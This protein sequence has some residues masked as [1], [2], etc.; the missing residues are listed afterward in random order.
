MSEMSGTIL[1][2]YCSEQSRAVDGKQPLYEQLVEEAR[3]AKLA[4]A[5]VFRRSLG[6]GARHTLHTEKILQLSSDLPVVVKIVDRTERIESF[7]RKM[8]ARQHA[9]HGLFSQT[10]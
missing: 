1:R 10:E 4:G 6:Y 5:T 3:D 2:I 7:R 8:Q 9:A